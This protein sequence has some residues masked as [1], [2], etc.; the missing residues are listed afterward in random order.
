MVMLAMFS[1]SNLFSFFNN[2]V[3]DSEVTGDDLQHPPRRRPRRPKPLEPA[4]RDVIR[5]HP[6]D[7]PDIVGVQEAMHFSW[8]RPLRLPEYSWL[9]E[10]RD[11]G[12]S[13][14]YSAILFRHKRFRS[15]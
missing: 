4:Q 7:A 1:F 14:E 13:G 10:G 12:T 5:S 6:S 8:K 11:G 3:R 2:A 15:H 9:G